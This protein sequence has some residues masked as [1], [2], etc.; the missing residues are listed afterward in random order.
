MAGRYTVS[1]ALDYIF[2]DCHT[3]EEERDSEDG[4]EEEVSETEDD[5]EYNPD[6]ETVCREASTAAQFDK[7]RLSA[8]VLLIS[9]SLVLAESVVIKTMVFPTE[10][11]TSYVLMAFV[12]NF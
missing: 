9:T 6:Q 7:M 4:F 3:D 10:T 5:T 2:D 11:S 1:E 8:V 12:S